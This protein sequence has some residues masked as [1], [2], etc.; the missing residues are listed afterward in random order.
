M[1]H[2]GMKAK[3]KEQGFVFDIFENSEKQEVELLELNDFGAMKHC[4]SCLFH[5][6]KDARLL[7]GMETERGVQVR[8]TL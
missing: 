2:A 1:N 6:I 8:V 7:Y 4:G 5:W 3:L